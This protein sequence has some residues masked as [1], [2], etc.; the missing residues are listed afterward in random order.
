MILSVNIHEIARRCNVSIATVS[1]VLN[2]KGPV[3]PST[4]EK[5]LQV[6]REM[7][8]R[9]NSS[10][11]SLSTR[12]TDTIGV[13]LPELVDEFFMSLI[14]ELDE[15][16]HKYG[17]YLLISSSHSSRNDMETIYEF[18]AGGRVDGIII[19]APKIN[20]Q[21]QNILKNNIRPVVLLNCDVPHNYAVRIKIDNYHGAR[22]VTKHL[23]E[24]GYKRI[25]MVK[26]PS[27]NQDA[28]SRWNGFMQEMEANGLAVNEKL[29]LEGDFTLRSGYYAFLRLLN[30]DSTEKPEAI[31]FANDMMALGAYHAAH[32]LKI[33]FPEDIA[34]VGFDDIFTGRIVHPG[35]TTVH[36]PIS[37]MGRKSMEYLIKLIEGE[38]ELIGHEEVLSTG[39]VI[40]ESCGCTQNWLPGDI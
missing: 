3:K 12:K 24:H 21:I 18:M 34:V 30:M 15:V 10:A 19:M 32:V 8:Y 14:H 23:I 2:N 33:K 35:L 20:K 5:V 29:I 16:A 28:E 26:G 9:P 4:R 7:N 27:G 13:I 22:S 39:L 38:E 25:A 37:E 11:R 31:F 36:M 6:A 17:K 40:R 1:R